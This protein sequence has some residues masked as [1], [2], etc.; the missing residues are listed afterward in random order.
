MLY[1]LLIDSLLSINIG[2]DFPL[3]LAMV[4]IISK[5]AVIFFALFKSSN[6]TPSTVAMHV[7]SIAPFIFSVNNLNLTKLK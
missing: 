4:F 6:G 5:P 7:S 1:N 2:A 3:N